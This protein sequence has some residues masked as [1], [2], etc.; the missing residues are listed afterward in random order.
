MA[1]YG[2]AL[3]AVLLA[4][5]VGLG[6]TPGS[7][8]ALEPCQ[9][10]NPSGPIVTLAGELTIEPRRA[11]RRAW[12]RAG[13]RQKLIK[14]ANSLGGRPQFPVSRVRYGKAPR[15]DLK[16][17]IRIIRKKRRVALRGIH[18]LARAGQPAW[19][20]ARVGKRTINF[21]VV[22][23][24]KRNFRPTR[25]ELSRSGP[26]RLTAAGA[27]LL[28]RRLRP[29]RKLRA[30]TYWGAFA[31]FSVYKVTEVEDPTGET[32]EEPPV[33]AVPDGAQTVTGATIKWYVRDTFI[34][35]VATGQGTRAEDGATADPPTAPQNL[36]YSFNFPFDT[37]SGSWTT[38]S[39]NTLI[40]GKGTVGFRYCQNTINFTVSD[41]EIEI[42]GDDNSRIIFR[43]NG[44]DGTPFPDQRA[45]MVKLLPSLA[46][47]PE[48]TVDGSTT[49]VSYTKI[50]GFVPAEGTGLF[51]DI[52]PPFDPGFEG[53][54]PRPDRFG[55][56]SVTYTYPSDTPEVP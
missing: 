38:G 14:P 13:V 23:G 1:L 43:V 36:S 55:F 5:F 54:D 19:V 28:N 30:G 21:L 27:K 20:R 7:A 40:K 22:R 3:V 15:V 41:P 37:D 49:T 47:S 6:A 29:A 34:N 24:G 26:A 42:D 39:G 33:K 2:A 12:R 17:G 45:V 18:V 9:A 52:Y 4:V 16:G 53:Q 25:G 8:S 31:L 44:T 48:V 46:E 32:P 51:A 50:P 10:T 56:V 11:T 35:Y